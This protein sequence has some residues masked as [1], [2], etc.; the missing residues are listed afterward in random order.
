MFTKIRSEWFKIFNHTE[1]M[2]PISTVNISTSGV[3]SG[4]LDPRILQLAAK[5]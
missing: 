2:N 3:V 5:L 4:R 1:F